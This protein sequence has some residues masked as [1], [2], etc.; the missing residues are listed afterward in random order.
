MAGGKIR[1]NGLLY[2]V[3]R[4][5]Q[6]QVIEEHRDGQNGGGGIGLLLT[7]DVRR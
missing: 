3:G 6:A 7:R 2:S 1:G 5:V 4:F